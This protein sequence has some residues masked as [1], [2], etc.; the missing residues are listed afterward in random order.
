MLLAMADHWVCVRGELVPEQVRAL[1][2]AG[3][4]VDDLRKISGGYGLPIQ[5]STL[6]TCAKVSAADDAEARDKVTTALGV[7][8]TDLTVLPADV[9]K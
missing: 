1:A 6:R 5:W 3:I 7:E 2:D 9:W 4:P 8:A